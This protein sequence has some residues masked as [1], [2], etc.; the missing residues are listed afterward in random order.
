MGKF[1]CVLRFDVSGDMKLATCRA[2]YEED[3]DTITVLSKTMMV[4]KTL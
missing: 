2:I 1:G 3:N 4:P